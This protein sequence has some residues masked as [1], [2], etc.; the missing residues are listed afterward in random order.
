MKHIGG[1][2]KKMSM[3]RT[4]K[5]LVLFLAVTAVLFGVLLW[6]GEIRY[7]E[8]VSI[9][10][11]NDYYMNVTNWELSSGDIYEQSFQYEGSNLYSFS[12]RYVV[13]NVSSEATWEIRLLSGP[14]K[15][16]VGKWTE[17]AEGI[18]NSQ[19][20][21]YRLDTGKK[22]YG[23]GEYWVQ[24][25]EVSTDDS[26]IALRGSESDTMA[27][28]T[29]LVDGAQ[30]EGDLSFEFSEVIDV[31]ITLL[32]GIIFAACGALLVLWLICGKGIRKICFKLA[33]AFAYLRREKKHIFAICVWGALIAV[34]A[35]L[36]LEILNKIFPVEG[37]TVGFNYYRWIFL[38][39]TGWIV[40]IL[41]A[42]RKLLSERPEVVV[43]TVLAFVGILYIIEIPSIA[44]LSWDESIHLWRAVGV[45]HAT[46][47][48]ANQAESWVY[49]RS[50]I[51][52]GLPGSIEYMHALYDNV[53][54][55]YNSGLTTAA[56]TDILTSPSVVA[57]LP[58][59]I[60]LK[61][62]R[63]LNFPFWIVFKMGVAANL[64]VYITCIYF[65]VK[66]LLSGKMIAT[67]VAA[68]G[69]AFFLATVYS[70]DSWI[71]GLSILGFAYLIGC[72]Q[73]KDKITEKEQWVILASL[74][75]AFFPKAIYFPIL[76][77]LFLVPKEKFANDSQ[78]IRFVAGTASSILLLVLLAAIDSVF[79]IITLPLLYVCCLFV[80][81]YFLKLKM[82]VRCLL[83]VVLAVLCVC[84]AYVV[85]PMIVGSGDM[86]G[87]SGVDAQAQTL[88]ILNDPI[89]YMQ[90]LIRFIIKNY[91]FLEDSWKNLFSNL[92]YLGTT[93]HHI[94]GLLLL[95]LVCATDKDRADRWKG[96]GIVRVASLGL[97]IICIMA[98]ASV[99]YITF[100]PVGT[101][102]IFGCQQRY[103]IPLI[104]PAFTLL[105][106]SRIVNQINKSGYRL[107]VISCTVILLLMNIWE[108]AAGLYV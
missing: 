11:S 69:T 61:I 108:L 59:A 51:P 66:K 89:G 67:V 18:L 60:M 104:F 84:A 13:E 30:Q 16:E 92:G 87:G 90:I 85:L 28:G 62:G 49:W 9:V 68:G 32:Y 34:G 93:A 1:N 27:R 35:F 43:C 33:R 15:K 20:K 57:Y 99:M 76:L 53:Q 103:M 86:R 98:I 50:G 73:K 64:A 24:I 54:T 7:G 8:R 4:G 100:T 96:H 78:Y 42:Q 19:F 102:T 3:K 17:S 41:F 65:S 5:L 46:T 40:L 39:F 45:S 105:G 79:L 63:G 14:E 107:A 26:G 37:A 71:T 12:L 31:K 2:S 44:E 70:S 95:F 106:S 83:V 72:M 77:L 29:F 91:L 48:I 22:A 52:L 21:E 25:S 55:I 88:G 75:V 58:A 23:S 47:G 6:S 82:S 97:A 101:N 38:T 81:K 74:T 36:L 94:G 56:N 80:L 10:N